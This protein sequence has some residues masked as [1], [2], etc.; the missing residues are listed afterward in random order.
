[1]VVYLPC[2]SQTCHWLNVK[3]TANK[4]YCET[5]L[6][7]KSQTK[8]FFLTV[9]SLTCREFGGKLEVVSSTVVGLE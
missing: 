1:M 6:C 2:V 4:C 5:N 7:E 9:P 8:R 3:V